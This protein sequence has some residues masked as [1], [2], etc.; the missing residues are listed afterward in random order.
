M[1]EL[2]GAFAK[3]FLSFDGDIIEL[4]KVLGK[5]L[6]L[7]DFTIEHDEY[8]PH[9]LIVSHEILG[10]EL[11]LTGADGSNLYNFILQLQTELCESEVV[12]DK[13]YDLSLWLARFISVIC[14]MP[15]LVENEAGEVVDWRNG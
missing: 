10:F 9:E 6:M 15:A 13:M 2:H 5:G 8:P 3:V 14:E 4:S 7:Q 11:W 1:I 12:H